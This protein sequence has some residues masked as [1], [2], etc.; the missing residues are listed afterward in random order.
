M[1]SYLGIESLVSS[2]IFRRL[3]VTGSLD[4]FLYRA[5]VRRLF[6]MTL[7]G[8]DVPRLLRR[9]VTPLLGAF[10]PHEMPPSSFSRSYWPLFLI[11]SCFCIL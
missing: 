3:F 1:S 10:A 5:T 2:L 11:F 9:W 4:I 8:G 6:L 7:G